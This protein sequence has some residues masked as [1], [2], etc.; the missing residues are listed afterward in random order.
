M[1]VSQHRQYCSEIE[2]SSYLVDEI[3]RDWQ[4]VTKA[5][6]ETI[7]DIQKDIGKR[8]YESCLQGRIPEGA[9]LLSKDDMVRLKRWGYIY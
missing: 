2:L 7:D 6:K 3:L 5:L 8:M 1:I 4:A 9:D